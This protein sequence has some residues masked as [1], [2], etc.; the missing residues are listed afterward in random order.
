MSLQTQFEKFHDKIKLDSDTKDELRAK[1]DIL[2]KILRNS[3]V[4]PSFEEFSQGSYGLHLGVEPIE[5]REYD[6]DVGLRFNV[7]KED[8]KPLDLK[9][10]IRDILK[11]HTEY[12][13][14]IKKPCVTVTYKKS[15]EKA[16]HVDL[17]TYAYEDKDDEDSQ[18][19][20]ALGKESSEDKDIRWDKADP[21]KLLDYIND[22]IA[23][24]KEREQYRRV[25]K[26]LKRWKH[27]KFSDT[28]H[29]EPPS[30]GITLLAL[31]DFLAYDGNDLEALIHT[32]TAIKKKFTAK[33]Y[34]DGRWLY[35]ICCSMPEGLRFEP[36]NNAFEKMTLVQMTNF[37]DKLEKL[38]DDLSEVK[39]EADLIKQ[40]KK[41]RQIFGEDF[42]VPEEKDVSRQQQNYIP[43]STASGS[44]YGSE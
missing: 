19:Y 1:R 25:V 21:V 42:E 40:C 8:Y 5:G 37:K 24:Q 16:F 34:V 10:H 17:V 4:L 22:T 13:A 26:Y 23:D 6:I 36:G 29:A 32:V 7:D 12:G 18:M 30:I 2:I 33:E 11:D 38:A 31:N 9:R 28:G 43:H 14:E 35:A 15:G 39:N 27:L 41:L 44:F 3:G 20:L